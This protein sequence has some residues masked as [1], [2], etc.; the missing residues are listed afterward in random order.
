MRR[1][2]GENEEQ[3]ESHFKPQPLRRGRP[4]LADHPGPEDVRA[5]DDA[6]QP[7]PSEEDTGPAGGATGP[8]YETPGTRESE[9][10]TVI[11]QEPPRR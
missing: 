4:G 5:S 11:H 1:D 9:A 10:P 8:G 3:E 6:P 2:P 7:L